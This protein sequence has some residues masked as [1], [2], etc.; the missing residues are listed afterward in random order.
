MAASPKKY[1]DDM[2]EEEVLKCVLLCANCHKKFHTINHPNYPA[3]EAQRM[4]AVREEWERQYG[5]PYDE[6][7]HDETP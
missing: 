2:L 4:Q 6:E 1:P 3:F 7:D 5:T